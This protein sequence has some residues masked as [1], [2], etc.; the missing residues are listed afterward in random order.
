MKEIKT[1]VLL[2]LAA[3]MLSG[4]SA[5]FPL[6]AT[7]NPIG[8]KTGTSSGTAYFGILFFGMDASIRTAAKNGGITKISTV[9]VKQSNI[10]GIVQTYETTVTGD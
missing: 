10:L 5:T 7:S 1:F 6:T 3:T 9:D 2:L 8:K 4:C